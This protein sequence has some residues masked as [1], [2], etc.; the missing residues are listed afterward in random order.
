MGENY[1]SERIMKT[2]NLVSS[3]VA[4]VTSFNAATVTAPIGILVCVALIPH[5]VTEPGALLW[6][7]WALTIGLWGGLINDFARRGPGGVFRAQ[8]LLM[9]AVAIISYG[10]ALQP[11]YRVDLDVEM[12]SKTFLAIG[13]FGLT[14]ALGSSLPP[15]PIGRRIYDL[16]SRQ[17]SPATVFKI[18]V[19]CWSLQMFNYLYA[20]N[21]SLRTMMSSLF[22]SRWLAPWSRGAFGGW[23]AFRDFLVNFGYV[24]PTFTI[25]LVL[26]RGTWRHRDVI[27]AMFCSLSSLAFIAQ[28]GSRRLLVVIV[29]AAML[30][31]FCSKK[32]HKLRTRYFVLASVLIV[33]LVFLSDFMLAQRKGG[34]EEITYSGSDF[35]GVKIDNN[36]AMLAETIRAIPADVDYI[37]LKF[38][39]YII[40]RPI[41]R[42]FWPGKPIDPGFDL[43]RHLGAPGVSYS[44]TGIGEMYM[45]FGWFGIAIG[46]FSLGWLA[47]SWSQLL[48]WHKGVVAS[49]LYGL[50]AMALF[51]TVRSFIELVLM[52]YPIVCWFAVDRIFWSWR[53]RK[54]VRPKSFFVSAERTKEA[55]G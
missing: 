14:V 4:T 28:S 39:W 6:S 31:W 34:Y 32:R 13:I 2:H 37:G 17:Y 55:N 8:H 10:E 23:D 43:A 46:G 42:V 40:I 27:L 25:A 47:A 19:L 5:D 1:V 18:L 24:V 41:P 48:D 12:V 26:L 50:G 15:L 21:F 22:V 35:E 20:S 49:A 45:S 52:T 38:P 16:A 51:L 36:F 3:R 29:G 30:T 54:R 9:I 7:A 44:I 53:S 33:G 11:F